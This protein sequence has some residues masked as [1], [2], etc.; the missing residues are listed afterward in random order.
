M[1]RLPDTIVQVTV[2]GARGQCEVAV[3]DKDSLC[4]LFPAYAEYFKSANSV[5]ESTRYE[6]E[7][8]D[9]AQSCS[10]VKHDTAVYPKL[11]PYLAQ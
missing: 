1:S 11:I 3:I 2:K 8:Q 5:E 4:K 9:E 7:L 6:E 10:I